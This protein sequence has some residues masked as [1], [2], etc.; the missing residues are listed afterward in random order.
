MIIRKKFR[1]NGIVQGV[2]FRPFI[3]NL[4]SNLNL[5]G[6]IFN[7]PS[8]VVI[9]AEG[10]DDILE[11]FQKSISSKSPPLARILECSSEKIPP[12]NK[13][14]FFILKSEHGQKSDTFI[15]PDVAVCEDCLSEMRDPGNR[16]YHYPFINCTNCGPRYSIVHSIP[17]DR[18]NTSMKDF[19]LCPECRREYENPLDRRFHAQPNACP[20]C[21]PGLILETSS[22][23]SGSPVTEEFSSLSSR[24]IIT[25]VQDLLLNGLIVAVRGIGG[26]HLAVDATNSQAVKRLR[27]RKGREEKPFAVMARDME[28]IRKINTVSEAEQAVLENWQRPI[29]LLKKSGRETLAPEV[30]PENA[31]FGIML[32]Y[33]PLHHLLLDG[34]LRYLVVTSGNYTDE[35]IAISNGEAHSRLS[36]I[37]DCFLFHNREILQ[38]CD[39]SIVRVADKN[40]LSLLR[41]SRGFVPN[42]VFIGK[43][44]PEKILACGPE[45]KNTIAFLRDDQVF[46]SQHIGDLDNPEAFK[47]FKHCINHLGKTLRI[48]PEFLAYDLHPEYLSTKWAMEQNLPGLGI[49]HHHA[50]LASVLADNNIHEPAIGIIL[51]GTGYGADGTIWGGE[52][53]AGDASGYQRLS[54]LKP[55]RL[56]GGTMAIKQPWRIALSLLDQELGENFRSLP[57]EFLSI[58]DKRQ[59]ENLL[60]ISRTGLNSPWTSSCGRLFDGVSALLGIKPVIAYEAQAAIT[61]EMSVAD[62]ETSVYREAV[63]LIT[64]QGPIKLSALLRAI[65]DDLIEGVDKSIIAARFHNTLAE[66]FTSSALLAQKETGLGKVALSGGVYQNVFFSRRIAAALEREG[67]E[68]ITHTQVPTNDGGISLGQILIAEKMIGE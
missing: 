68:V 37:A 32:P 41:R 33:S 48:Q 42:P 29:V 7:S 45:L 40:K 2:G 1:V 58:P 49:Q 31:C 34:P 15:S 38:R 62:D 10:P 28:S 17:Y 50:H 54:W 18:A 22:G 27:K 35:P 65:I 20:V 51:D 47:F 6:Y 4:A 60:K 39:D 63:N 21:G 9:E 3:Y 26:F 46:I 44:S 19:P 16:R 36:G 23:D 13:P 43:K 55:F 67:F 57:L 64:S 61:M 14:G 52:I 30:A 8:G 24:E 12:E 11:S 53:L 5:S 56:P 25:R 59:M 66:M